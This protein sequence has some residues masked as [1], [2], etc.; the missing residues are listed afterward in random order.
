MTFVSVEFLIFLPVVFI[1]YWFVFAKSVKLQ[2]LFLII[3]SYVFYGWWDVRF[4]SLIFIT[5]LCT[6]GSGLLI[7]KNTTDKRKCRMYYMAN[8]ILNLFILAIFKYYNFFVSEFAKLFP[9]WSADSLLLKIILPVGI[10]FYTFQ[11]LAY[12]VD[13]YKE[14]IEPSRD[15]VEFFAFL[16]F[17]PQL[18]AG[19]I[20]RA[21][22]LLPQI[23]SKRVFDYNIAADGCRQ[24]LWGMFKK[25]A[26]ADKCAKFVDQIF[27]SGQY[28]DGSSLLFGAL[29]FSF[30]IYGDFS[31]YS[32]IAIG[33]SKLL[34]IKLSRNFATPFF[35]RNIAEFWRRWHITL[36]NWFK[37]YVFI[38]LGGSRCSTGKTVRNVFIVFLASGLWHGANW[39][40]IVWGLWNAVIF[41]PLILT[42]RQK[43]KDVIAKG[44]VFPSFTELGQVLSTF[45]LFLLGLVFFRSQSLP[46]AFDY[47]CGMC[48]L[49]TLYFACHFF[50]SFEKIVLFIFV[51]IMLSVEWIDREKEHALTLSHI[52]NLP[53]RYA[54][55]IALSAI[56]AMFWK[57][58]PT[59][60]IYFQF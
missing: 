45:F 6:W 9:C 19:P 31:G 11:A 37:D 59:Q 13:V 3:A 33:T 2:N 12:T 58:D 25:V 26:I 21:S 43:K 49:D 7:R 44:K 50:E 8:I 23:S 35:S 1:L 40:Y 18:V 60:F 16:S 14:K 52:S 46:R 55:Y 56:V 38:P 10:S 41:I 48:Q 5:S 36:M 47:F 20:E 29:L 4:L 28:S 27:N 51:I 42:G 39:T 34:G 17:F 32:D 30:Q 57:T 53:V 15:P 22:N 24:I 54:I